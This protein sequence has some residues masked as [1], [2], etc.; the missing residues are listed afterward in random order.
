MR[1]VERQL[2]DLRDQRPMAADH[3][4]EQA[5]C[6]EPV[7]AALL[8]VARRGGKHQ[9]QV[10]RAAAVSRKRPLERDDQLVRRAD[11]DEARDATVSPSRMIATASSAETIL[12]GCSHGAVQAA[13][14]AV[15]GQPVGDARPEEPLRLAAD[16]HADMAAGQRELRVILR[17]R[18]AAQRLGGRGRDDVVVLGEHVEHRHRDVA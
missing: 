4:L 18:L 8:A 16:E 3:A 9:G 11:A 14:M 7:E 2:A 17:C 15:L 6:A 13:S 5:S 10:R 1:V 12:F